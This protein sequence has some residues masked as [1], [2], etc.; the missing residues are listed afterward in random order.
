MDQ[1]R[2]IPWEIKLGAMKRI[3][4]IITKITGWVMGGRGVP[5]GH[6]RAPPV[7]APLV[8]PPED[9]PF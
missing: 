1:T 4:Q 7:I 6:T 2:V 9:G 8:A 5:I 3:P